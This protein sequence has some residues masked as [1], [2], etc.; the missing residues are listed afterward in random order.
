MV[1]DVSKQ[2]AKQF[3]ETGSLF[4]TSE[5]LMKGHSFIMSQKILTLTDTAAIAL[6]IVI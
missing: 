2:L 3:N 1:D 4:E 6:N 5:T